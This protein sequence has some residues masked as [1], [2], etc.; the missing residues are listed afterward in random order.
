MYVN[1]AGLNQYKICVLCE[2]KQA[3][4]KNKQKINFV[5]LGAFIVRIHADR[6]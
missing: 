5:T 1:I 6:Y 2:K 4:D 3:N